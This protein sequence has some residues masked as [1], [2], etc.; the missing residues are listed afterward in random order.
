MTGRVAAPVSSEDF[1]PFSRL[2]F[3]SMGPRVIRVGSAEEFPVTMKSTKA[4]AWALAADILEVKLG[5]DHNGD[6]LPDSQPLD[7]VLQYVRESVIPSLKR[8]AAIIERDT[9]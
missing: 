5:T 1:E 4:R 2:A 3:S 6:V 8:R 9:K 7:V